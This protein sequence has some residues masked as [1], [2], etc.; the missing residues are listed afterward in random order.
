MNL[1]SRRALPVVTVLVALVS[2]SDVS[3]QTGTELLKQSGIAG[4]LVVHEGCGDGTLSAQLGGDGYLVHGLDRDARK[5]AEARQ[6]LRASGAYGPVSLDAWDGE[7]LPYADNLVNLL[8]L[9]SAEHRVSAGE[10]ARVLA[11]RGVALVR[12]KSQLETRDL[13]LAAAELPG[14]KGWRKYTKPVPDAIDDWTHYLHGADG[15]PVADDSVVGP[16]TRLQ[17]VGSPKWAR[18]HDHMASM[19][20][21]VSAGG[22]LFYIFDEGPTASIQLPSCWKL[23][24]RDAFNG[25]VLWKRNIDRWNTRHYPLKSGPAHLLRRLVAVENRVYVTLGIDAPVMALDA[26]TGKTVRTYEGS[27]FTREILATEGTLL[28][29]ADTSRSKLPDWRRVSTYVW[30]NTRKANVEWGWKG[31]ARKILAYDAGSGEPLWQKAFPVA[32][33]SLAADAE[34]VVFHDG[35]K[36][37]CLNRRTGAVLWQG[38]SAPTRLP[39]QT[40]TGPRVLLHG[41]VVLLAANN[42]RMSG[43]DAATGKLLWSQKHRPSGHLSLKDLFVVDGL[44]WTG[45]VAGN[46]DDGIFAGYDP[47]TG[48]I[49]SE[50]KP[51]VKVHWFHHRCYPSKAAGKYLITARQGTEYIDLEKQTWKPNHWVRGGCIYGVMPCNGMTYAPMH[52]CGCQLE[53]KL[54]G[55]NALA[56]GASKLPKVEAASRLEKGPAYAS[57]IPQ[58]AIRNPQ[59]MDWP[60]Y[61]HDPGRSGAGASSVGTNPGVVWSAELGGRLTPPTVAGGKL[62]VASVDTHTVHALD[63]ATGREAWAFT[64]GGRV[65]SPPTCYKGLALFGSADGYVYALRATDGRLAWRFRAAPVDRRITAWE[66]VESAWP[67]H[68]SVLVHDDVLYCTAGRSFYLDGGVRML[69]LDPVTGKLLGERVMDDMDPE[70][71]Q[72][73]HRAYLEKT[74][75]NNMPVGLSDILS[76]D[77]RRVWM[78]SQKFTLDGKRLEIGLKDINEQPP[79]DCHLF[80]QVGFLDDSY[81]FRS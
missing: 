5:V 44:A 10:I 18:H 43:W 79:E 74:A 4:G 62:Y 34:R 38:A 61:R 17:W 13:E 71:D 20:S 49:K 45:A 7:N 42:D 1:L 75:G 28:L 54:T 63:V 46:S 14:L 73:M 77:G 56:S 50:F 36:L 25:T 53:A 29:V 81:F 22:R 78:R 37:V 31:D 6:R 72:D 23:V 35:E 64:A 67:V 41:N 33:C 65:D 55:F 8:I 30:D 66:Q 60:T 32:P 2:I 51:D 47:V 52:A 12:A 48:E 26:A 40:N 21:L 24:A 9:S 39:V 58:S 15:N 69:R 19:T 80:C 11:P 59:L 57:P 3:G 16:P 68:G 76:C 70:S 27:R